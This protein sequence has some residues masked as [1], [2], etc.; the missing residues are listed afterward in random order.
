MTY[1][2]N[3]NEYL[4]FFETNENGGLGSYL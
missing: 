1:G 2:R 3:Q 4:N